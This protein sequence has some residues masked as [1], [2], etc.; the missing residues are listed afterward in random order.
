MVSLL[1]NTNHLTP[2]AYDDFNLTSNV[3]TVVADCAPM[4][5]ATTLVDW[6]LRVTNKIK[7]H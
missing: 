1:G 2:D 4:H 5:D 7:F 6:F 3:Q